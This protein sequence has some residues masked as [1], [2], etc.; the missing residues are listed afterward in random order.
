MKIKVI[1]FSLAAFV[2]G[3]LLSSCVG[4]YSG[5]TGAPIPTTPVQRADGTGKPFNVASQDLF[6]AETQPDK[7]W[8]LYDAGAV[9]DA[10]RQVVD[11][12]K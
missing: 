4:V 12:G 2:T 5:I 1:L 3:V 8:G 7:A 11:S 6:R 9:S 10:T